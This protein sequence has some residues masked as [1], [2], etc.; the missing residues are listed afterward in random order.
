MIYYL[1]NVDLLKWFEEQSEI[2]AIVHSCN[3]FHTMG[4]GI[5]RQI[6][7]KYP[8]AYEADKK[9]LYGTPEKLGKFSI[10]TLTDE[11]NQPRKFI[12]NLYGQHRYGKDT[13]HTSYDAF[14]DGLNLIKIDAIQRKIKQLGLPFNIGCN[15]GGGN[16]DIIDFIINYTFKSINDF[17]VKICK[18]TPQV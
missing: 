11:S 14:V 16:W 6:S 5:A 8:Q 7:T 18:Y 2:C 9:T 17:D 13:R 3:C 4:G 15:L 12:Y 10:A 1:E